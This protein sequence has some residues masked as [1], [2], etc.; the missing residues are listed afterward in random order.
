MDQFTI[1]TST[2]HNTTIGFLHAIQ[3]LEQVENNLP[4]VSIKRLPET[5]GVILAL[6]HET[7]KSGAVHYFLKSSFTAD[8]PAGNMLAVKK[9]L[10]YLKGAFQDQ[11]ERRTERFK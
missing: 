2:P 9:Q 4:R 6:E 5:E 11:M 3:A 8:K 10:R 7:Q 1:K